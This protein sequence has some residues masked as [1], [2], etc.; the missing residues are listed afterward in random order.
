MKLQIILTILPCFEPVNLF[1]PRDWNNVEIGL[2][3]RFRRDT[4]ALKTSPTRIIILHAAP[5]G[6]RI[7]IKLFF[8]IVYLRLAWNNIMRNGIFSLREITIFFILFGLFAY[9]MFHIKDQNFM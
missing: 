4:F 6:L 2:I 3:P 9:N 5:W 7:G 8:F 1:L